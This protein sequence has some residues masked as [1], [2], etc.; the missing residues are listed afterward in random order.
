MEN[1]QSRGEYILHLLRLLSLFPRLSRR[2]KLLRPC[3]DAHYPLTYHSIPITQYSII[4]HLSL[5]LPQ[6][7]KQGW[8]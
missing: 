5:K 2:I 6:L 8:P 4:H 7:P 1:P 3:L